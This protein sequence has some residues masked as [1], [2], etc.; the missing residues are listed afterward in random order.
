MRRAELDDEKEHHGADFIGPSHDLGL[1]PFF[2]PAS[3]VPNDS[4]M[5]SLA[6]GNTWLHLRNTVASC[7]LQVAIQTASFLHR[8]GRDVRNKCIQRVQQSASDAQ[9]VNNRQKYCCRLRDS[10]CAI[11]FWL[12]CPA[13]EYARILHQ[14]F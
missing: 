6:A 8:A 9:S 14:H 10:F 13:R 12:S 3:V 4:V 5:T 11:C 2:L 7:K 1:G